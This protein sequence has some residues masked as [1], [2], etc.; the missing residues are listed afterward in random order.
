MVRTH[1][2]LQDIPVLV[3]LDLGHHGAQVHGIQNDAGVPRGNHVIHWVRKEPIHI[4]PA[5]QVRIEHIY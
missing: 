4:L 1:L 2:V 5:N 3:A